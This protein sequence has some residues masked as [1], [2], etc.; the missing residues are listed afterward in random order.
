MKS[1]AML[2]LD[3]NYALRLLAKSP[4]FSAL[5]LSVI[6]GGLTISLF[7]FSVLYTMTFKPLNI[8]QGSSV[9]DLDVPDIHGVP[10][11]EFQQVREQLPSL[12]EVGVWQDAEVRMSRGAVGYTIAGVR[13]Q[14]NIFEFARTQPLLGRGLQ[15]QDANPGGPPVAVISHRIWQSE[16][17]GEQGIVGT[18]VVLDNES[19]TIVGVMPKG[20]N[21]PVSADIWLPFSLD[22]LSPPAA[23]A[24][25]VRVYAR[26]APGVS[27]AEA[28]R[29]IS[30]RL[31][32]AYQ[33]SIRLYGKDAAYV[34]AYLRSY[35]EMEM[36]KTGGQ[37][38]FYFINL[39]AF[40]IF[41][42]AAVNAGNV[43]L[44]RAIERERETA[45]RAALGAP[46]RRLVSQLMWEGGMLT[47]VG[48]V[49]AVLLVAALLW[50]L[51]V[52]IRTQIPFG[53]PFWWVWHLEW[54]T[55][56][57]GVFF[58]AL[59]LLLACFAPAWRATSQNLNDALR[60]GTRAARGKRA[61]RLSKGLV[62]TQ[63]TLITALMLVG[64]ISAYV[65]QV[66][67]TVD[68]GFKLDRLM[69][70]RLTLPDERYNELESARGFYRGLL[71]DLLA[72]PS[73]ADAHIRSYYRST[74]VQLFGQEDL[75][76]ELD[77]YAL[78][79]TQDV[80][81]IELV[82]GRFLDNRDDSNAQRTAMVSESFAA[83]HWPGQNP[84]EQSL[85]M[86]VRQD[87]EEFRVVGV[88]SDIVN[89]GNIFEE[90]AQKD[91]V[92]VSGEI[93]VLRT[94]KIFYKYRDDAA[95][96]QEALYQAV[97]AA[98]ARAQVRYVLAKEQELRRAQGLFISA[99]NVTFLAAIFSMV[100]A[101]SGVYGLTANAIVRRT[102]EIGIR[103]AV[104]APDGSIVNLLLRQAS[105]QLVL[106][107][108]LGVGLFVLISV[109][110]NS[111]T[112]GAI[113]MLAYLGLT[114]GVTVVVALVMIVA[115]Y[116]PSKESVRLEPS[117]ALRAE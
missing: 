39:L 27:I 9:L 18:E 83:R 30:D 108:L 60:D 19:M 51:N 77:V 86:T 79:G 40:F 103:R 69:E 6:V 75:S 56:A 38:A 44:A 82:Q 33:Q 66:F 32:N 28:N 71:N 16:F 8:P 87:P 68:T 35:P 37:F 42:L 50:V 63:V 59:M 57:V 34:S 55:I 26:L 4:R 107:L 17:G 104:G 3:F 41:L 94:P 110:L 52:F 12:G 24:D 47:G 105:R 74:P 65:V 101:L 25:K 97:S 45:I 100:L 109:A 90:R 115:V 31:D 54:A 20:F 29:E 5:C 46:R 112:G 13:S 48:S 84:L 22:E 73:I 72:D 78:M 21:F 70:A 76:L 2:R 62:V 99:R 58:T 43:L 15:P 49:V 106:G 102:H 113:P 61:G 10:F 98:D 96:G 53:V 7:T 116:F 1:T 117:A 89:S 95:L 114:L 64:S 14:W 111:F 85:T 36:E 91:E 81:G 67:A 80:Q 11:Y 88:V 23:G 92:Y 93:Y